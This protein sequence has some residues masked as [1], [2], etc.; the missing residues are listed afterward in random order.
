VTANKTGMTSV[1]P[2]SYLRCH[3]PHCTETS[4]VKVFHNFNAVSITRWLG[5]QRWNQLV[6]YSSAFTVINKSSFADS[7]IE[8]SVTVLLGVPEQRVIVIRR[9]LIIVTSKAQKVDR[10]MLVECMIIDVVNK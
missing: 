1:K 7:A 6:D 5:L 9:P 8:V 3:A 2:A 10:I 4:A